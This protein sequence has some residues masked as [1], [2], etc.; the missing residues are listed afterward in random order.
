MIIEHLNVNSSILAPKLQNPTNW[1]PATEYVDSLI[2]INK[3]YKIQIQQLIAKQQ[4]FPFRKA[5]KCN[6][7]N[8]IILKQNVPSHQKKKTKPM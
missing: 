7:Q 6:G 1:N 8:S 5:T 3:S 2:V 4:N